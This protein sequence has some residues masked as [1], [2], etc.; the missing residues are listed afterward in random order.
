[1]GALSSRPTWRLSL[2]SRGERA[3]AYDMA[4]INSHQKAAGGPL[5]PG[6]GL[7]GAVPATLTLQNSDTRRR[8]LVGDEAHSPM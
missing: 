4:Y 7:S 6:F 8:P 1:V 2:S 5:K 3:L